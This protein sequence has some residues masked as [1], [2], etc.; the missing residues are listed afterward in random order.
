MTSS[1]QG[2]LF[3]VG[4]PRSGTTLLQSLLASHPDIISFP[5]SHFFRLLVEKRSRLRQM[6]NLA[7]PIARSHYAQFFAETGYP[8]AKR[9]L[10]QTDITIPQYARAFY[11][12]LDAIAQQE[13]KPIWLEKTPGHVRYINYIE[14]TIAQPKF[15][16]I[17]RNGTDVVA[18]L[19]EVTHKYPNLWEKAY[20]VD[21][22]ISHWEKDVKLTLHYLNQPNHIVVQYEQLADDPEPI[23]M[24]L[25]K[26]IGT[27][28]YKE[29]L[30][31]Y[32]QT[33]QKVTASNEPW[34]A[35]VSNAI[36]KRSSTKFNEL[37]N[38]TERQHI[39][40]AIA[41]LNLEPLEQAK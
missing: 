23:L 9:F 41:T 25:C 35:G 39:S 5:E 36:Q 21:E 29:M 16:H 32:R 27:A 33:A 28:F 4:C 24:D 17:V 7:S 2:R 18:S 26:F 20:S 37:F 22:C 8:D 30:S 13:G 40:N 11:R 10:K 38:E 6:L 3:L 15:I 19:Y 12:A 31:N 14:A 1:I 34:K